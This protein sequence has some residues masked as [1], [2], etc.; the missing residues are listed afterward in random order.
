[1]AC[2]NGQFLRISHCLT[3]RPIGTSLLACQNK[4]NNASLKRACPGSSGFRLSS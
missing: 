4:A 3:P 2:P 1:M